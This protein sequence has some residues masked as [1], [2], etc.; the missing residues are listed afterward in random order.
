MSE[1]GYKVDRHHCY[2]EPNLVIM[3]RKRFFFCKCEQINLL[4]LDWWLCDVIKN[5]SYEQL[6]IKKDGHFT[7]GLEDKKE[8]PCKD[9]KSKTPVEGTTKARAWRRQCSQRSW[10]TEPVWE[11]LSLHDGRVKAMGTNID[12]AGSLPLSDGNSWVLSELQQKSLEDSKQGKGLIWFTFFR[13]PFVEKRLLGSKYGSTV[14]VWTRQ[15]TQRAVN[16]LGIYFGGK[17]K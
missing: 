15:W 4:I 5:D 3:M 6:W 7:W 8:L 14:V 11:G 1:M 16:G 10:R 9:W 2:H 12:T 17:A 13:D